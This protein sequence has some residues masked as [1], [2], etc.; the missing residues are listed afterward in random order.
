VVELH[1]EVTV[2]YNPRLRYYSESQLAELPD[3]TVVAVMRN[4]RSAILPQVAHPH[5]H[6]GTPT[7]NSQLGLA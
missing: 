2:G 3:G 7:R 1:C 4:N 5:R 6:P